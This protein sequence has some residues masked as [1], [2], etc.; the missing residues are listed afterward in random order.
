MTCPAS[1]EE[2]GGYRMRFPRTWM[3]QAA[4]GRRPGRRPCEGAIINT[5]GGMAGGD[6]LSID[7]ETKH[8]SNVLLSTP[9]AERVYNSTGPDTKVEIALRLE[10][11]SRLAW[12]PRETILFSGARLARCLDVDMHESATL[13]LAETTVFGRL[14]MGE[15]LAKGLFA[16]RWRIRRDG[17]LMHAEQTRLDG[18]IGRLLDRPAIGNGARAAAT[19]IMVSPQAEDRLDAVRAG[20]EGAH[21]ECGASAWDGMLV[22]R[23]LAKDPAALQADLVRFLLVV[24]QGWLPHLWTANREVSQGQGTA[25][26]EQTAI[27]VRDWRD[28]AMREA[29]V[30][31]DTA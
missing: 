24:T 30:E 29:E 16:D 27:P 11:G 21:G 8:R 5:G 28:A 1:L 14:A 15:A 2:S 7:V 13:I 10:A 19:A 20:L 25:A 18:A 17:R 6:H 3:R 23:F 31:P 12:L 4:A 26:I 9:S 22:G